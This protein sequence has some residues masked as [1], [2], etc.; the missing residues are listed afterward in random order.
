MAAHPRARRSALD[1]GTLRL[2]VSAL[3]G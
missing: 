1:I 3:H 2:G